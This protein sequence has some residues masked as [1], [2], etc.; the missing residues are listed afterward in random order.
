MSVEIING[1]SRKRI[2]VDFD[3]VIADYEGWGDGTPGLPRSD[4]ANALRTLRDEGWFI[5][6]YSCRSFTMLETYMKDHNL[7][8]DEI[9]PGSPYSDGS[10]KP[11]ASIYWDDRALRYSG[12]AQEDLDAIRKFR[13]WSG[14]E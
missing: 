6:V 9:N 11:L 3:G 4:V 13:T 2:A 5:I 7:P 1:Q 10:G 8:F 14:R 12:D